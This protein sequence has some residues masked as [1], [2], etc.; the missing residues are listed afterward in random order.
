MQPWASDCAFWEWTRVHSS[1]VGAG[2][3]WRRLSLHLW[4]PWLTLIRQNRSQAP[5]APHRGA[6]HLQACFLL[7]TGLR[8]VTLKQMAQGN[9]KWVSAPYPCLG[10]ANDATSTETTTRNADRNLLCPTKRA[11]PTWPSATHWE[12]TPSGWANFINQQRHTGRFYKKAPMTQHPA[13]EIK[14]DSAVEAPMWSLPLLLLLSPQTPAPSHRPRNGIAGSYCVTSVWNSLLVTPMH[15]LLF[16][17]H[18][19]ECINNTEDFFV[20]FQNCIISHILL[21]IVLNRFY[22]IYHLK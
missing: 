8:V 14:H 10:G 9:K 21:S 12:I 2:R 4:T 15:I 3:G 16:V 13:E 17:Q 18:T 22:L 5:R 7:R 19:S 11:K 1:G 6:A 20:T